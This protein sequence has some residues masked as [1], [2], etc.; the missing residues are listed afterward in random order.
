VLIRAEGPQD[1]EAI[2]RVTAAAFRGKAYAAPSV[3]GEPGEAA[4]VA[5]LREDPGWIP[6]LSLVAVVD[7]DVVGHVVATRGYMDDEP[8]LGLGPLSVRP[9]QQLRGIGSALVRRLLE[10]APAR[11]ETL[12]VVLGDPAYYGRFGFRPSTQLGVIAPD[13]SWGDFFQARTLGASRPST[14]GRFRYAAP[15]DR[16]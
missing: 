14:A 2:R 15:F 11:G 16:L 5:W 1:V 4:L 10:L 8:A 9:D 7:D 12:L 6:D 13:E 3:D